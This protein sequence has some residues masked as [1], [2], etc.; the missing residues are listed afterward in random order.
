VG[1]TAAN[2][3]V[4]GNWVRGNAGE[5]QTLGI[6]IVAPAQFAFRTGNHRDGDDKDWG[7]I[8]IRPTQPANQAH[9]VHV[10]YPTS[11]AAWATRPQV[12][13][14]QDDAATTH[15]RLQH[16]APIS[17]TDDVVINHDAQSRI[18][19]LSERTDGRVLFL[20]GNGT[21][22][23]EGVDWVRD[24]QGGAL[25]VLDTGD[26]VTIEAPTARP[27]DVLQLHSPTATRITFNGLP[28]TFTRKGNTVEMVAP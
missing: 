4:D 8:A 9:F 7:Y 18:V 2:I 22:T 6:N 20:S 5:G 12:L 24:W 1:S 19:V 28:V 27:G 15:M 17:Q 13:L 23:L 3:Q 26:V 16:S 11:Q 10:L 25:Q 21:F 14:Q